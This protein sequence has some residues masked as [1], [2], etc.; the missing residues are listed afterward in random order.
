MGHVG[1]KPYDPVSWGLLTGKELTK[2]QLSFCVRKRLMPQPCMIWG[3]CAEYPNVSGSQNCKEK[4]LSSWWSHLNLN[5]LYCGSGPSGPVYAGVA[6]PSLPQST[7]SQTLAERSSG[8]AETA[9]PWTLHWEDSHPDRGH[10]KRAG[11]SSRLNTG[12]S[13][14]QLHLVVTC[15]GCSNTGYNPRGVPPAHFMLS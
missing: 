9:S 12:R 3:S 10:S 6:A 5:P 8:P 7:A 15:K 1:S 11:V 4:A 2:F 14:G 13:L